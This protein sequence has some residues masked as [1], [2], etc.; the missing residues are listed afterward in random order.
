MPW[1]R[2]VGKQWTLKHPRADK[3]KVAETCHDQDKPVSWLGLH[4]LMDNLGTFD[5]LLPHLPAGLQVVPPKDKMD[6]FQ[7]NLLNCA[8]TK[9]F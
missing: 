9:Y 8:R 3:D 1:G 4:G 5:T 7:T 2:I 6:D